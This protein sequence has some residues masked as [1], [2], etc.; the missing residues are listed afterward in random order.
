MTIEDE[1]LQYMSD[2]EHIY[3]SFVANR[4]FLAFCILNV[5]IQL[6]F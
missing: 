6:L 4:R 3:K 5:F 1:I 2:A